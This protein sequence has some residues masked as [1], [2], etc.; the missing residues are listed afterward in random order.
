MTNRSARWRSPMSPAWC[1]GR[2]HSAV[3]LQSRPGGRR[4]FRLPGAHDHRP[5]RDHGL[6]GHPRR[7]DGLLGRR[8]DAGAASRRVEMD[9]RQVLA[10]GSRALPQRRADR[11][12]RHPGGSLRRQ[13]GSPSAACRRARVVLAWPTPSSSTIRSPARDPT[14]RPSRRTPIS[15]RSLPTA[16]QPFDAEWM[17]KT[18][19]HYWATALYVTGWTNALLAPPPPHV[20]NLSAR[21]SSSRWWPPHRQRFQQSGRLLPLA[22]S[23]GRS[24]QVSEVAGGLTRGRLLRREA[25][26]PIF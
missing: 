20:L 8:Q 24:G 7:P 16:P 12:Q 18:F 10:L 23:P 25:S 5:V 6:R 17:Q 15:T 11:R 26:R 9:P 13:C 22:R 19:D 3:Q 14:R 4:V 21:P 2:E 1:R